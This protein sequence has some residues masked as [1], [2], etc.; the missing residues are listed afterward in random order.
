LSVCE[1][2][3]HIPELRSVYARGRGQEFQYRRDGFWLAQFER[4]QKRLRLTPEMFEIGAGGEVSVHGLFSMQFAW[5]R[6]QAAR[7]TCERFKVL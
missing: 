3:L 4:S 5:I 7:R 2:N 6:K 1:A